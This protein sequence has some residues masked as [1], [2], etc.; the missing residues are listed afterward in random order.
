MAHDRSPSAAYRPLASSPSRPLAP[1][2]SR[3]QSPSS[4]FAGALGFLTRRPRNPSGTAAWPGPECGLQLASPCAVAPPF[5]L[6]L[7]HRVNF[8]RTI[9]LLMFAA[10]AGF[11]RAEAQR[12]DQPGRPYGEVVKGS[13]VGTGIFTIYF[14]R[15]SIYLSLSPRQLDRDYLLVTQISQ[16]I[17]ELGLD[18]GTSHSV[19]P[20]PLPP[21]GRP[22][23]VVGREPARGRRPRHADGPHGGVL[24]RQLGRPVVPD[25]RRRGTRASS[26]SNIAPFFLS[27]WADVGTVFQTA[28]QQ[29]KL[30]GTVR[31]TTS[32]RASSFCASSAPTSRPRC[33]SRSRRRGTWG[34]RPCPTTGPFRSASTTPC[35]SCPPSRCGRALPTTGWATSSPPSR[36]SRA[37]P[38]RATSSAT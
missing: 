8:A 12:G 23:G 28:M 26:W 18:G 34:S 31:S 20:R 32:A 29:R 11:G 13:E 3:P 19:R 4:L 16:G 14:K 17:G 21:R 10:L 15:D 5:P 27:D 7:E 9:P 1:S 24:V 25:R 33:G 22:G 30:T 37:T 6:F 35:A 36:I 38:P 2:P